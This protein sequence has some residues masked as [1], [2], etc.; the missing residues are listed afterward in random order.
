MDE[1]R[2]SPGVLAPIALS[3]LAGAVD[4]IGFL[5]LGGLFPASMGANATQAGVY[6]VLHDDPALVRALTLIGLFTLGAVSGGALGWASAERRR[7]TLLWTEAALIALAL[8]ALRTPAWAGFG[9]SLLAL[10]MGLQTAV[11]GAAGRELGHAPFGIGA[12]LA[13]VGEGIA[14]LMT[15][16]PRRVEAGLALLVCL[17]LVLGASAGALLYARFSIQ[18]LAAPALLAV[19]LALGETGRAR[20]SPGSPA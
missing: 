17:G 5:K 20:R 18:A 4:A 9:V 8:V 19:V 13:R 14:A 7:G 15:G 10:A 2:P 1:S 11:V 12:A 6:A 16:E 3:A